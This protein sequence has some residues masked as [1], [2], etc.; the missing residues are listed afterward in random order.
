MVYIPNFEAQKKSI[1]RHLDRSNAG[2][3][4]N[5]TDNWETRSVLD[6]LLQSI[7]PN[8]RVFKELKYEFAKKILDKRLKKKING[9][10]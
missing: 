4:Y 6:L 7:V 8:G 2:E 1:Y 3:L 10:Y 5:I 9:V